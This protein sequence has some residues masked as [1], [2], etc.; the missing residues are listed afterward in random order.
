MPK[1]FIAIPSDTYQG[2][3]L[4]RSN[5]KSGSEEDVTAAVDYGKR[6]K[7]YPLLQADYPSATAARAQPSW[8]CQ[9]I[10]AGL[11]RYAALVAA[12]AH[13]C[14]AQMFGGASAS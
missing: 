11:S 12:G 13:R 6:I 2:F 10:T 14:S 9:I 7:L 8:K 5:L 3:A 1:G 4:L